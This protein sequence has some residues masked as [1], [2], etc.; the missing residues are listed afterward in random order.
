MRNKKKYTNTDNPT[1]IVREVVDID[2]KRMRKNAEEYFY[3]NNQ[4][5][6]LV[7]TQ[8]LYQ[9]MT[10]IDR[11]Y[12]INDQRKKTISRGLKKAV[13]RELLGN[14]NKADIKENVYEDK[15]GNQ[16]PYF[17]II[18]R[19]ANYLDPLKNKKKNNTV[20]DYR[21]VMTSMRL[22]PILKQDIQSYCRQHGTTMS[23]LTDRLYRQFLAEQKDVD[24]K[25]TL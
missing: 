25:M 2:V 13:F 5:K 10:T 24:S 18:F 15:M 4:K 23:N 16:S 11:N 19:N 12:K 20:G 7:N 17:A 6:V 3:S 22:D 14:F 1:L 8:T 9:Y 21:K